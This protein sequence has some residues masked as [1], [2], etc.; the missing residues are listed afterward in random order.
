MANGDARSASDPKYDAAMAS[1]RAKADARNP[2]S[3]AST[4]AHAGIS[5]E[6]V[7][8]PA[9]MAP[10]MFRDTLGTTDTGGDQDA[11]TAAQKN[12]LS[13]QPGH[14]PIRPPLKPTGRYP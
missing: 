2:G 4:P 1:R 5:P 8:Y 3:I 10:Q 9:P 13:Q 11:L 12:K 14:T 6:M 7:N